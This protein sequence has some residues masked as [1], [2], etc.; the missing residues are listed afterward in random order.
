MSLYRQV[1][2]PSGW[3]AAAVAIAL[4]VGLALGFALA[5]ATS[6]EPTLA[7]AVAELQADAGPAA[8]ALE[9]VAIH[10]GT[11][12]EAARA[13][14]ERA[15]AEFE[16]VEPRLALLSPADTRNAAAQID[17]LVALVR[18]AAPAA[19]VERA[20]DRA[21]DAVRHAARLR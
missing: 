1:A 10:Y 20:A 14:L 18:D 21:R 15:Q 5:R 3:V 13:Q 12:E 19:D 11:T 2:R 6:S 17:E 4:V 9:L 16:A 7:D 8:D